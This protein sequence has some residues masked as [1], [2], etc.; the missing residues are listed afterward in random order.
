MKNQRLKPK[1]KKKLRTNKQKDTKMLTMVTFIK[2]KNEINKK[3]QATT[4]DQE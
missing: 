3:I 4:I 2:P 1:K